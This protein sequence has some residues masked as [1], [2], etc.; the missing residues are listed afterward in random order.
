[1]RNLAVLILLVALAGLARAE[2]FFCIVIPGVK[3]GS[4]SAYGIWIAPVNETV[5]QVS[6]HCEGSCLAP[7]ATLS[8]TDR[9]GNAIGLDGGGNLACS[10]GAANSTFTDTDALD[11]DR[12][13]VTG[14][15]LKVSVAN[16]PTTTD[17]VTVCVRFTF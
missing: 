8:F 3:A 6:C 2:D 12:D 17:R 5:S 15:G 7:T 1:M 9:A 16:T 14:E 13:L 4:P 10:T 11:A